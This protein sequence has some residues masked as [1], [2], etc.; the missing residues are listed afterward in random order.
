MMAVIFWLGV[1]L[2]LYTYLLYP[3]ILFVLRGMKRSK[4]VRSIGPED[5]PSVTIVISVYNEERSLQEKVANLKRIDYPSTKLWFLFGSD[6]STDGTV[7]FL[8]Q[9]GL[10]N[11]IVR[12][13]PG[14]RGKARVINDLVHDV[15]TE[16]IVFSDANTEFDPG[17]VRNLVRHFVDP[18]V[19]SV[20]GRLILQ[21][22]AGTAG[23][24]G[25]S[26]YW[27]YE[28]TLKK[29]ES[30]IRTTVGATGGIYAIRKH[31]FHP[32]PDD[33]PVPDDFV[34]PLDVLAKGFRILY[35]PEALAFES[36]SNSVAREFQRKIRIGTSDFFSLSYLL[37]LLT[38]RAGFASFA[39]WSR[40]IIRWFVPL[41]LIALF[42]TS[43]ALMTTSSFFS[44][45]WYGQVCFYALA[46]CGYLLEKAGV[47]LGVLGLPYYFSAMNLALFIGFIRFLRGKQ[48]F[49]WEVI[50]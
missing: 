40:K 2:T 42:M 10:G 11:L 6:G 7:E 38:P 43:F 24:F 41:V 49:T 37:P 18:S 19:G 44:W 39:L 30:E 4:G 15:G 25:E 50:R 14:R 9:A 48:S 46:V 47:R 45:V 12:H 13:F 5:L 26:A 21:S 34:V 17:T 16:I 20:C 29:L 36:V 32:L 23:G 3:V 28:N 33:V 8:A 1:F 31:L 27:T 35:D 22:D